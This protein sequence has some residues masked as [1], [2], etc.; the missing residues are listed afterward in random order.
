LKIR[1]AEISAETAIEIAKTI[2]QLELESPKSKSR[3][4]KLLIIDEEQ[5]YLA[6]LFNF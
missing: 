1:K 6:D 5:R 4:K 3:I 2:F